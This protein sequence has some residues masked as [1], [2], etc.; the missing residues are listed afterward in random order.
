MLMCPVEDLV[1]TACYAFSLI[2][3]ILLTFEATTAWSSPKM[4]RR[5]YH[6]YSPI[7][8]SIHQ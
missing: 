3:H 7:R 2:G 5:T 1:E 4:T 6:K 8:D